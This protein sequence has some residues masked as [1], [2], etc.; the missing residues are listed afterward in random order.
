[1]KYLPALLRLM[2]I[3]ALLGMLA[4]PASA[5]AVEPAMAGMSDVMT[6]CSDDQPVDVGCDPGCPFIR[7]CSPPLALFKTAWIA[8]ARTWTPLEY[9][10]ARPTRL[11]SLEEE[12][13]ARPPKA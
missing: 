10:P 4:A 5:N 2:T 11:S 12:P 9:A 13:P 3:V 1:M 6:C 7:I 8:A